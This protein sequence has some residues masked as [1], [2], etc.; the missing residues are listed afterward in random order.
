[1][2]KGKHPA[3]DPNDVLKELLTAS[4]AI[5]KYRRE[6]EDAKAGKKTLLPVEIAR[7]RDLVGNV[8]LAI[9]APARW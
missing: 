5:E 1:M 8:K 6:L 7:I 3:I 4:E 2:E 9:N